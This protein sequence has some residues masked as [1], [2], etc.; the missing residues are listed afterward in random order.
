MAVDPRSV[1]ERLRHVLDDRPALD[2]WLPG[3]GSGVVGRVEAAQQADA[4]A[5]QE[6]DQEEVEGSGRHR[7]GSAGL[8]RAVLIV[9]VLAVA[10]AGLLVW[11]A[12]PT[13][14]DAPMNLA[15]LGAPVAI[16]AATSTP[17]PG[18]AA[19]AASIV[20]HVVGRVNRPGLV[21]LPAGSRVA[22]AINAAGGL[23]RRTD[24]ATVNL[25][26]ALSDGEQLNVGSDSVAASASSP[27]GGGA[28]SSGGS[29]ASPVVD[30]NAATPEQLDALPG[31]G[32]VLAQRIVDYRTQNGRFTAVEDLRQVSGIGEKKYA[33]L[34]P[35]VRV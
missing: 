26:R 13:T 2:A 25:A 33:D 4:D 18:V 3:S 29:G 20:V 14:Q 24:P 28:A 12:R 27:A 6:E 17:T 34:A 11:R 21:T 1:L 16:P 35:L 8:S 19:P 30:L 7:A 32:P 23:L 5:D 15:T 9:C 22:D 10:L 31:V